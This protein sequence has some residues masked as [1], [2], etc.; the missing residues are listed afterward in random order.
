MTRA[1]RIGLC[2]ILLKDRNVLK[3]I[4]AITEGRARIYSLTDPEVDEQSDILIVNADD[5]AAVEE[6][7]HKYVGSNGMSMC[8]TVFASRNNVIYEQYSN[9]ALPFFSNTYP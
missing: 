7:N 3:R 1:F 6:W 2:G 5:P 8:A 4:L 9:T